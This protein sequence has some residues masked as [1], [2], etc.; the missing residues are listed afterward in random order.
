VFGGLALLTAIAAGLAWDGAG[1]WSAGAR[2]AP[3]T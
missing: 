2:S 1:R 3:A